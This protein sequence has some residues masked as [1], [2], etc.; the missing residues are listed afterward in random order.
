MRIWRHM[1]I[2]SMKLGYSRGK[3]PKWRH[4]SAANWL[5]KK[6]QR[7]HVKDLNVKGA[8][9]YVGSKSES[10]F[11]GKEMAKLEIFG[12]TKAKGT[13]YFGTGSKLWELEYYYS[14]ATATDILAIANA[15]ICSWGIKM[16]WIGGEV[17]MYCSC[18]INLY[19]WVR[20]AKVGGW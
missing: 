14:M 19:L 2:K 18:T 13:V 15:Q 17:G 12:S 5:K 6:N 16:F 11:L 20:H 10:K 4:S 1:S 7:A 9:L 8:R 3:I